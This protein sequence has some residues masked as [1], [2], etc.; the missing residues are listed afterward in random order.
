MHLLLQFGELIAKITILEIKNE[1]LAAEAAKRNVKEFSYLN[2]SAK[3]ALN[4]TEI[5]GWQRMSYPELTHS[6]GISKTGYL[7]RKRVNNLTKNSLNSRDLYIKPT[8]FLL[9]SND[10]SMKCS[11]PN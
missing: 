10:I 3:K 8:M 6:C 5:R 1:R 2:W 4:M 7:S 11:L 9:P